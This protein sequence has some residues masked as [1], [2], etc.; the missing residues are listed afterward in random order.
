MGVVDASITADYPIASVFKQND[1]TTYVAHNY[2]DSEITVTYSD[3]F[4]LTVPANTMA[5]NRYIV[6]SGILSSDFNQAYSGGSV[7]LSAAITGSGV[8]KVEFFDGT[9]SMG[10]VTSAPYNFR[11]ENITLGYHGFYA[12]V[13]I[14]DQFNVTNIVNVQVG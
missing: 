11:A 10:E 5:T 9:T 14:N 6:A 4:Q 2:S 8:T 13:Y 7:Q 1:E 12:K 3:G